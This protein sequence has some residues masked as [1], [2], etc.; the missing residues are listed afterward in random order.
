MAGT[1]DLSFRRELRG[2]EASVEYG[3]TLDKDSSEFSTALLFGLVT[4]RQTLA[5]SLITTIAI[6]FSTVIAVI[7][8]GRR[9]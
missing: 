4:I 1:V 5:A 3:N 7:R 6:P 2:V 8:Q 9:F